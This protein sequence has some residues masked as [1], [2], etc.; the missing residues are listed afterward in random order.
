MTAIL[1]RVAESS[2]S[3]GTGNFVLG[4]AYVNKFGPNVRTFANALNG[5]N[6]NFFYAIH[7]DTLAE[8]ESGV[9]YLSSGQLVR[10]KVFTSSNGGA[11]VNFSAGSKSVIC[12]NEASVRPLWSGGVFAGASTYQVPV[13]WS[14]TTG[15][16]A[17][18]ADRVTISAYDL[19]NETVVTNWMISVTTA[20]AAST[21]IRA[22]LAE[23]TASGTY[24]IVL[25]LGF[26]DCSTAGDKI[27]PSGLNVTIPAGRYFLLTHS[28]GTP[29][30]R[31]FGGS[32]YP[33]QVGSSYGT[34]IL[35]AWV[36]LTAGT[37][38][39]AAWPSTISGVGGSSNMSNNTGHP[40]VF[41]G[42]TTA[43]TY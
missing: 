39:N 11:L 8:F 13:N 24:R 14:P 9:G 18:T 43:R 1:N 25:D 5:L 12:A 22:A 20:G 27:F 17:M 29:T 38:A 36:A 35:F 40:A 19:E 26:V 16:M 30:V 3:T 42:E 33:L 7:H 23:R 6:L 34:A 41:Y 28:N 21:F 2:A 15:T 31:T 32:A 10:H 4:G 37:A